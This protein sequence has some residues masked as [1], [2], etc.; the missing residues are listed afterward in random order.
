VLLSFVG[1]CNRGSGLCQCNTGYD[2]AACERMAC[3]FSCG[4]VGRCYSMQD[5]SSRT[6]NDD[7]QVF[8]Y[9]RQWDATKIV[10]MSTH[11]HHH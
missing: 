1:L 11:H 7:S 3:P 10:G 5:L 9:N 2:G 6:T 8:S 4:G